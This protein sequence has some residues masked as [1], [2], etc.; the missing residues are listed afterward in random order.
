MRNVIVIGASG[1]LG[2]ALV[3]EL[4]EQGYN[5]YATQ[6]KKTVDNISKS[7][8][9]QGGIRGLNSTL[10]ANINPLTIYHCGRPTYSRLKK[11]GRRLAAKKAVRLNKYLI[12]QI[13]STNLNVPLVF[14]SGSLVY[15]SS[16]TAHNEGS[17]LN[18]ISY[19]R[20]YIA[21][22]YPLLKAAEED[23]FPVLMLRFPWI[24]GNGSWFSW[25]YM[26]NI[27]ENK[28]VPLF[29]D[30]SN[31]MS[32]IYLMD[33]TK[34]MIEYSKGLSTS[35]IY[36]I[37]TPSVLTQSDFASQVA[38]HFNCEVVDYREIYKEG[39][40]DAALEAFQ[41]NILLDS[42]YKDIL[43]SYNFENISS[44]LNYF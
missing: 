12:K 6:N 15:G 43:E 34:M 37:Y 9:I 16:K 40:E 4:M 14:A 44:V 10:I 17:E 39:L 5:V 13:S 30:G 33:A 36:N 35:G 42:G 28:L 7:N 25:F 41:S 38:Q 3:K 1:Y 8:I 24:I 26:K 2:S 31:R 11:L 19:S 22:E 23:D 32:L 18:P 21:G 20:Q 27:R 29:G